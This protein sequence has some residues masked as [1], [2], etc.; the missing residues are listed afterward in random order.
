MKQG[1]NIYLYL[2]CK[3]LIA[4]GLLLL[5]QLAFYIF[6]TRLFHFVGFAEVRGVLWGNV[7]FAFATVCTFLLPYLVLNLL[8]FRYRW[9]KVYRFFC[10]TLLYYVPVI[11]I[12]AVNTI[13]LIYFQ[14]TYRRMSAD[15]FGY[16]NVGGDMGS[17][18]PLFL[19]DYWYGVVLFIFFMFLLYKAC[20][21]LHLAER[22]HFEHVLSRDTIR[23]IVGL[24]LVVWLARGGIQPQWL[25]LSSAARYCQLKNSALVTNSAYSILRTVGDDSL[26]EVRVTLRN[27][28]QYITTQHTAAYAEPIDS[29]MP[30][31]VVIIVLE[32]F[33]QEYMGCYNYGTMLSCTPFLDSLSHHAMMYDGRSNGKK[34]IEGLPAILASLPTMKE[35]PITLS[36]WCPDSIFSVARLLGRHGY[37]S[38]FFHNGYNGVL[39]F[40]EMCRRMGFE[41]Y[42]GMN[43]FSAAAER[44]DED[45]DG[46]WGVYDMPF[47]QFMGQQM[48]SL[49]EPFLAVEFTASS[50]HPYKLPQQY[51]ELFQRSGHPL[52][53]TVMYTDYALRCFFDSVSRQ[54]W[55]N[56]TLFV[57]TADHPGQG[58]SR[59]YNDYDGWY[60]I[61][62]MF[63]IPSDSNYF[64]QS[65]RIMQQLDIMP[66]LADMLHLPDS[67]PCMGVSA[68][69]SPDDGFQVAYGNGFYFYLSNDAANPSCH[70]VAAIEGPYQ[71][72][73]DDNIK[74]L[75]AFVQLYSSILKTNSQKQ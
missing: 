40:D 31:N 44:D 15:M 71:E 42:F 10:E 70:R 22:K 59:G 33:S 17:L 75:K 57:I 11:A 46:A 61:P 24:A 6:N 66:T 65:T 21:K 12:L 48:D 1:K 50:H 68:V 34:S 2:F 41:H 63:Y 55:Y 26:P 51:E 52:L 37:T 19:R 30:K 54:P 67:F 25:P 38:A 28:E 35:T 69:Q 7:R 39:G 13:D 56:N 20:G 27:P 36:R 8:P 74:P 5:S 9:K 14:F 16:M 45:Y 49:A 72:G 60:S 18:V 64:G 32:S 73:Y 43:E 62:M 58:L 53:H 23:M 4:V 29:L 47:L 3:V